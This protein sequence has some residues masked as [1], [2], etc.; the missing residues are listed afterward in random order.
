MRICGLNVP[1]RVWTEALRR[2]HL[3]SKGVLSD[4][5]LQYVVKRK[6]EAVNLIGM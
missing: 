2:A 1:V 3:P 5:H 6:R 4:V